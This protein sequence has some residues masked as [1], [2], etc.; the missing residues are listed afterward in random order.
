VYEGVPGSCTV[1]TPY[2]STLYNVGPV[3]PLTDFVGAALAQDN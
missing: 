1:Y 2:E 3:V